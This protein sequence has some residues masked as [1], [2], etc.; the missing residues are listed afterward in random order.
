[1]QTMI[2]AKAKTIQI[3]LPDGNPR[4]IRI[5]EITSRTVAAIQIP[6]SKLDDAA[7]RNELT[8][9]CVYL[10]VGESDSK[11]IVYIGVK[12]VLTD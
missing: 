8:N 5:A 9:V 3:F 2:K 1:M 11:P 7:K 6:R 10:L 4:G 12:T